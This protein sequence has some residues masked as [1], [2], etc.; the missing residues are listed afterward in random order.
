MTPK[1]YLRPKIL[2][3]KLVLAPLSVLVRS[4]PPGTTLTIG[5]MCV[6]KF[7]ERGAIFRV[8]LRSEQIRDKGLFFG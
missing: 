1:K 4:V 2:P 3:P 8:R 7:S 5:T 6:Q